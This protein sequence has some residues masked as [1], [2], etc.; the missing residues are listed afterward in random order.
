MISELEMPVDVADDVPDY[1]RDADPEANG[2]T[3]DGPSLQ[4]VL[5]RKRL[6]SVDE[7]KNLPPAEPLI[8]GVLNR[9]K[10]AF[11][12]GKPGSSKSFVAL[13]WGLSVAT[14]SF[15]FGRP[16]TQGLVVYLAAEGAD[17]IGQRLDAWQDDRQIY[18]IDREQFLLLPDAVNLLDK[19][20]S[21]AL[22]EVAGDLKPTLVIADTL[23]RSMVG[24][25]ENTSRDT[26]IV[27]DAANRIQ[28]AAGCTV[29]F[30][31]HDTREGSNLRG[32]SALDG[33]ADTSIECKSDGQLVLL[34][35]RKQ[36]DQADFPDIRLWRQTHR[37]SCVLWSHDRLGLATD[38]SDSEQVL[39]DAV[40]DSAGTNGL[41]PTDLMAV[42]GLPRSS[43]FRAQKAL[44][45]AGVLTNVGTGA[46]PRYAL[47]EE[48]TT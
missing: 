41:S 22:V 18:T 43:Y 11:L 35:S 23:A 21:S 3:D 9:R 12:W 42:T 17:G 13:D 34:K 25:E 47:T 28:Q 39:H 20:W 5:L 19:A 45:T 48:L 10:L 36:K 4:A 1:V 33:A 16:V 31:H 8:G 37:R 14:G 46:R 24:G 7:V 30:V 27:V 6:L 26:G 44:V 15:W 32:S 29:L 2:Y 40:R 38:L